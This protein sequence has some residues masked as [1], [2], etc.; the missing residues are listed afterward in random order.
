MRLRGDQTVNHVE[1]KR[2]EG[3]HYTPED[4]E[5]VFTV[6]NSMRKGYVFTS[7]CHSVHKGACVAGGTHGRGGV[8]GG[9]HSRG[10]AWQGTMCNR[11]VCGRGHAWQQAVCSEVVH[12]GEACVAGGCMA[13]V[14]ARGCVVEMVR[15]LLVFEIFLVFLE[16]PAKTL[17]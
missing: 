12:G 13:G 15:I 10:H 7:V 6:R 14:H 2:P 11:G 1:I 17:M 9:M 5:M 16:A 3:R 4:P 8:V